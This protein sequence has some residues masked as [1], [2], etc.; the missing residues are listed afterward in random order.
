MSR[1]K[2]LVVPRHRGKKAQRQKKKKRARIRCT[3]SRKKIFSLF[4]MI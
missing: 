3:E 4:Q 1:H 2:T